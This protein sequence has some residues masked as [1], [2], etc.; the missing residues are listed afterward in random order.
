[1]RLL[2]GGEAHA[3]PE[4]ADYFQRE[5]VPRLEGATDLEWCGELSHGPKVRLLRGARALL[6]PLAWEEPFG[7]VMIEAMLVGT[8]VIGFARGSA[9]EVIEDGV[10]GF[11]VRDEAE[12]V[13]RIGQLHLIDRERCRERA[14]ERWST[15]RMA[16]DY[17]DL[18]AQLVRRASQTARPARRFPLTLPALA[19]SSLELI[20]PAA[21]G[22]D[23][24]PK[25]E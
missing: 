23:H 12:M 19:A 20:L 4:A 11:L 13:K 3:I 21:V 24:G 22:L 16:S 17:T 6:F 7:L 9:P 18:Y 10:T 2:L 25:H 14:I 15:Q 5:L 8:P 1:M